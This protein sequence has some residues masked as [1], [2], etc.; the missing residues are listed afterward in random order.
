[1]VY[2]YD[3]DRSHCDPEDSIVQSLIWVPSFLHKKA[4]VKWHFYLLWW[5]WCTTGVGA[6]VENAFLGGIDF[7]QELVTFFLPVTFHVPW[8]MARSRSK[9]WQIAN[10]FTPSCLWKENS[11]SSHGK[12]PLPVLKKEGNKVWIEVNKTIWKYKTISEFMPYCNALLQITPNV[13]SW[14]YIIKSHGRHI[15]GMAF[16]GIGMAPLGQRSLHLIYKDRKCNEWDK[17]AFTFV[18]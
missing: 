12:V 16:A 8:K 9:L 6:V 15:S 17:F 2:F 4:P 1:M 5:M 14:Q 18:S 3:H 10:L 7:L 11:G 13:Y